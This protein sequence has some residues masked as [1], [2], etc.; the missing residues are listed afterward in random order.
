MNCFNHTDRPAIGIC[1]SC[2]KG[3]CRECMA[4]TRTALLCGDSCAPR[5]RAGNKF[6]MIQGICF[7]ALAGVVAIVAGYC[8][9]S[10]LAAMLFGTF[11]LIEFCVSFSLAV[12]IY[13]ERR[14]KRGPS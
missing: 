1:K 9:H 7:G 14:M 2:G 6:F 11:A 13:Y 5:I 3:L 4:E 12:A 10:P 8:R